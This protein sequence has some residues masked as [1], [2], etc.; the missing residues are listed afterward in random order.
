MFL[1]WVPET[2]CSVDRS[3]KGWE[4]LTIGYNCRFSFKE[5]AHAQPAAILTPIDFS[6]GVGSVG[7]VVLLWVSKDGSMYSWRT[8]GFNN[9]RPLLAVP[10]EFCAADFGLVKV[11]LVD[12][13]P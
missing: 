9:L 12:M 3:F 4:L 7:C 5:Y 8:S 13:L 1:P 2:T 11:G 10:Y 6:K